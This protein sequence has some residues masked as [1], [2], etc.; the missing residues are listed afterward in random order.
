MRSAPGKQTAF[1]WTDRDDL[2]PL[3]AAAAPTQQECQ[4]YIATDDDLPEIFFA[5]EIESTYTHRSE[6]S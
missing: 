5:A 4:R 3:E 6:V 1:A 2:A